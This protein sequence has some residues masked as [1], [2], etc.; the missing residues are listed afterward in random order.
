VTQRIFGLAALFSALVLL[1]ARAAAGPFQ[2]P[3][4][5]RFIF[6]PGAEDKF[7]APTP[8]KTWTTGTFGCVRTDGRQMHEGL[9]IRCLAPDRQGEPTDPILAS[10]DGSVAYINDKPS[11]SNYGRY[12]ILRHVIEGVEIYTTYAHLREVRAGLRAGNSVRAG[13]KIGIM[14]RTTN[15]RSI[16]AK[17]RA[18][19]HFE[20]GMLLNDRYAQWQKKTLP[21]QRN[22]HG[23]WNGQNLL[24]LDPRQIFLEQAS[25]GGRFSLLQHVRSQ[26]ELCRVYV[27]ATQFPWL[28]RYTPLVKRNPAAEAEG[29]SGY[30]IAL[31]FNGIPFQLIP[32]SAREMASRSHL[33]IVSVNA[34]EARKNPCRKLVVQRGG[35]WTLGEHGRR[36]IDLLIY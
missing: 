29:V 18:H 15:T 17:D 14:G 30:E 26:P 31:N 8:G 34:A 19:V 23:G 16:I 3:T 27:K 13:E 21:G 36:L 10:A 33:S 6:Q 1:T 9:D 11:L 20:I 7:F 25:Q 22:D 4:A 35:V 32:R 12:I 2:L 28:R 5:N 24:G